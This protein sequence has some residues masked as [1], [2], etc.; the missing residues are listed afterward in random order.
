MTEFHSM[1]T[2]P[3]YSIWYIHLSRY[4]Y[5]NDWGV[6]VHIRKLLRIK[7][8]KIFQRLCHMPPSWCSVLPCFQWCHKVQDLLVRSSL[9]C[10]EF[11]KTHGRN[12]FSPLSS[13]R[14]S[15]E[16]FPYALPTCEYIQEKATTALFYVCRN[17]YLLHVVLHGSS[18]HT[19]VEFLVGRES[20]LSF[21]V[22]RVFFGSWKDSNM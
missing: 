20:L 4:K 1:L 19:P 8:R 15:K 22:A 7:K 10:Y 21:C 2:G 18:L 3:P 13:F 17:F 12:S 5:Y 14:T 11:A 6:D 9:S 16:H